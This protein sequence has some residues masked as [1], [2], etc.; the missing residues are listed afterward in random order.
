M[1]NYPNCPRLYGGFCAVI[2]MTLTNLPHIREFLKSVQAVTWNRKIALITYRK[3]EKREIGLLPT[4]CR[5][6]DTDCIFRE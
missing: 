2:G 4:H 1:T 3:V 5:I 6:R